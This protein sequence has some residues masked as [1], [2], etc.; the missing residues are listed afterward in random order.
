MKLLKTLVEGGTVVVASA[1]NAGHSP[2]I[3]GS[4]STSDEAISVAASVDNMTHN[5]EFEASSFKGID[6]FSLLVEVV[7]GT[8]SRAIK[9]SDTNP[10]ELVY[11]KDNSDAARDF[12]EEESLQ[13]K[14]KVAVIDRGKVSFIDKLKRAFKAGA[15]GALV[16]NNKPGAPIMMGE[17]AS[18]LSGNYDFSVSGRY[19]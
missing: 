1:G 5:I 18:R 7:Q 6:G 11:I 8:I 9:S 14:G 13:L 4:P 16:V 15:K 12:T 19:S 17:R 10:L 2:Y 3:V